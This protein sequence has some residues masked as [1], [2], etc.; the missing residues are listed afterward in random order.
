LTV[1]TCYAFIAAERVATFKGFQ[2]IFE[3]LT[4]VDPAKGREQISL[5]LALERHEFSEE[6]SVRLSVRI[7][8]SRRWDVAKHNR[9]VN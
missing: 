4:C 1:E 5:A 6:L 8:E 2:K 9:R 7:C 3:I